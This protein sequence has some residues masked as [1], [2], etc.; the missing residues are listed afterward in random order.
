[1]AFVTV[2]LPEPLPPAIPIT[3]CGVPAKPLD[4][5]EE[6]VITQKEKKVFLK[7]LLFPGKNRRMVGALLLGLSCM[8]VA[9][10][11]AP[12]LPTTGA[13]TSA[14]TPQATTANTNGAVVASGSERLVE[15]T[16]QNL[17][18]KLAV[19]E[20]QIELLGSVSQEWSDSSLGCPQRDMNYLQVVTPGFI[21][22]YLAAGK[23]YEYHTDS[24]ENYVLCEN[25]LG[26]PMTPVPNVK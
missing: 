3:M 17:V 2:V 12:V 13:T 6:K 9:C 1:M 21:I 25:V 8:L 18:Q 5:S 7:G 19:P 4:C 10:A 24:K 26:A 15:L 16:K 11:G 22:R 20:D 23:N 14:V